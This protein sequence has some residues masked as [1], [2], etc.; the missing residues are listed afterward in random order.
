M[1]SKRMMTNV[2]FVENGARVADIG[3][4]HGFVSIYLVKHGIA[5]FVIAMDVGE[6]PLKGARTHIKEAGFEEKILTRL[7]DGLR[8]LTP[9]DN[10]DTVIIAGLGGRLAIKI[11]RDSYEK[12]IKLK[13]IIL[14]PQS[15]LDFVRNELCKMG[16]VIDD[17]RFIVEDGK[18][19]TTMKLSVGKCEELNPAEC[20]YGPVLLKKK[21]EELEQYLLL[22]KDKFDRIVQMARESGSS[23]DS[24][25]EI[26]RK[27]K[28]I[29]DALKYYT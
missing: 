29:D 6:E 26:E 5:D 22:Q 20:M 15:E 14:Q 10:I 23:I 24:I 9:Q 16:F 19:Y 1:L 25:E 12:A 8:E 11:L 4:D 18:H 28:V 13:T 2:S 3:C 27:L 7:S 21:D 17:E